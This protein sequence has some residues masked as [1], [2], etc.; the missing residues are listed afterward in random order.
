MTWSPGLTPSRTSTAVPKVARHNYFPYPCNAVLDDS[1][2]R[3][4]A[5]ENDRFGRHEER[6]GVLQ[7][8]MRS[9]T[10]AIEPG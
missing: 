3:S 6:I 10:R 4:L 9:S 5:I 2:L 1:D 7:A 8:G